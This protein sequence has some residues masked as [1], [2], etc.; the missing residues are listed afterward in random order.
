MSKLTS[1]IA[2]PIILVGVFTIIA[3]IAITPDEINP[4]FYIVIPFLSIFI[5]FFGLEIGKNLSSPIKKLLNRATELTRGNLSSRV[6]LESKDE[7]SELANVFN[8]LAEELEESRQE[9]ENTEKS[10]NVKVKARTKDLEETINALEQKVKNRT[11]E[12]ERLIDESNKLQESARN[13]SA[14]ADQ[15]KKELVELNGKISRYNKSK[16]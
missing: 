12:I 3:L 11:I 7:F 9:K 8:K 13:K 6:Y 15:L 2:A 4:S 14:E 10:V 5:F 1:K 16:R